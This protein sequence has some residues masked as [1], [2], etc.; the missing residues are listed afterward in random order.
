MKNHRPVITIL[1]AASITFGTKVLTDMVNHS[2]LDGAELRF[3]DVDEEHLG[4]YTEVARRL[5][6][7]LDHSFVITADT[8]RTRMLPQSD[9][10]I[11]SVETSRY[12]LWNQDFEL[13][14]KLGSR[15]VSAE[16]GGPGGLFHSLRQIPLHLEIS[17]DIAS[18]CPD[19]YV[20][21]ESNP[22][23][24]I[25]FAMSR[26]GGLKRVVGLC[27]GVEVTTNFV[28]QPIID[29]PGSDI[30]T[31]A[32]GTNHLVWILD[33]RRQSTGEDLYPLLHEKLKGYDPSV[34]PLSRKLF[35]LYGYF[36]APGDTHIGE[37]LPFAHEYTL[38]HQENL[39]AADRLN[40]QRWQ[41]FREVAAGKRDIDDYHTDETGIHAPEN[42]FGKVVRPRS[43]VDTLVFPIMSSLVSNRSRRMPAV[44]VVNSGQISNLPSGFFVETPAFVDAGG[45]RAM[46]VGELPRELAHFNRRD[47]EQT[48]LIAEA[49][50]SGS[51]RLLLQAALA[52]PIAESVTVT[53][54]IVD[55]M[56]EAQKEFL[57]QF[58]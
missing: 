41:H 26:Y 2:E 1:G 13:P 7:K 35:E 43:W 44:N 46:Q 20:F 14:R 40:E 50:V 36:P 4:I 32:A 42:R 5:E 22:L 33:M 53:E 51:R 47:I 54:K 12:Q 30:Q 49:A 17:R 29:V 56:L 19:A 6:Q 23:N 25:C 24:R 31:V 52:D 39:E 18:L 10:V 34:E 57:P 38:Y 8:G 11:V 37:Y 9:Y 55:A 27:H 3:V 45:I 15:Q 48:E 16:L 28:I 58:A 21:V